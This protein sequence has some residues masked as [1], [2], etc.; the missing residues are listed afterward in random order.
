[1][2]LSDQLCL[3][4]G[5]DP[6][7]DIVDPAEALA[8]LDDVNR[9]IL[10]AAFRA[11]VDGKRPESCEVVAHMDDDTVSY[12][13]IRIVPMFGPDG[14]VRT[15]MGTEQDITAEKVHQQLRDEV[16]HMSR[17]EA[18]NVMAATIAHELAQPLTA[19][20]NYVAAVRISARQRADA[21]PAMIALLV[22]A[23]EQIGLTS[24]IMERARDMVA[25]GTAG[26]HRAVLA[27]IVEDAIALVKIANRDYAAALSEQLDP[28]VRLVAADKVQI[29]QVLLNLL[30]NACEAATSHDTPR[31]TVSSRRYGGMVLISVE[32]NGPGIPGELG[33]VFSPFAS[34]KDGGLGLGLSIC[35]AIVDSY[36]GR[37]WSEPGRAT[38]AAVC[39]T[40]P[41]LD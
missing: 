23:G 6:G 33:D 34:S 27:E 25:N 2:I 40:L 16:A 31:V 19:A 3:M 38:G 21:D 11:A 8:H 24:K 26:E 5:R 1:V 7:D 28:E 14:V 39:F 30:R 10:L 41:S 15:L 35:R 12:R 37:I 18:M 36:G 32:D 29:Q 13:R 17:V 20:S 4:Y 22:K 9:A